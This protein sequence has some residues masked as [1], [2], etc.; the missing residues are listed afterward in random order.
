[1]PS[2]QAGNF[3]AGKL[4]QDVSILFD[5]TSARLRF[6]LWET[7]LPIAWVKSHLAIDDLLNRRST[8]EQALKHAE[9]VPLVELLSAQGCFSPEVKGCYSLREA[10]ELFDPLRSQWY[11]AYYAHPAWNL[12]RHGQASRNGL[13]AW[14][15]HNYHIS[16][17]AGVAAARMAA[18]GS[19]A[20]WRHFFAHDALDE[21]WHC[22]AYYSLDVP[23]MH[24][25]S[26]HAINTSM[27]LPASLAFEEHTLQV[28]ETNPLGHVLIAYFQES[29]IA[30][31]PDSLR[32]Y[33]QV[34]RLYSIEGLF[35]PWKQHMRIDI[36]HGHADGLAQLLNSEREVSAGEL[37]CAA[38]DAWLAYYFLQSALDNIVHANEKGG[39][40]DLRTPPASYR[41]DSTQLEHISHADR[42]YLLHGLRKSA[43]RA[44]G[45]ARDHIH[46]IACG[47]LA[48]N[49]DRLAALG[50]PAG[51]CNPWCVAIS[52][53]VMEAAGNPAA[54]VALINHVAFR[55]P[56]LDIEQADRATDQV[57][58]SC[59]YQ[60]DELLT[61]LHTSAD[62]IPDD[63]LYR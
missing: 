46:I 13:L 41:A 49:L 35:L 37:Q 30:F 40:A 17:A 36:E 3:D 39:D 8:R 21:Y 62:R 58:P 19:F 12:I 53:H 50:E 51:P 7:D 33:E 47:R 48:K 5:A 34:E 10:K 57:A 28:A 42:D 54:W 20:D 56:W 45:F 26:Q 9:A 29:S 63:L 18:M 55:M 31:E 15:I 4:K 61:C 1:M 23:A 44:L 22:D 14:L 6:A 60:L 52:N 43:F 11:A 24:D 59:L 38:R 16:R 27:P 2:V 32:F 25:I